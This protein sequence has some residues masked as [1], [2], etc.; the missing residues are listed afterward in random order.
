MRTKYLVSLM[1]LIML[2]ATSSAASMKIVLDTHQAE[3]VMQAFEAKFIEQNKLDGL[4]KSYAGKNLVSH[5]AVFDPRATRDQYRQSLTAAIVGSPLDDDPFRYNKTSDNLDSISKILG[6]I[7]GDPGQFQSAIEKIIN[8]YMPRGM[9]IEVRIYLV[10]GG[11]STGWTDANSEFFLD[12]N[13]IRGDMEGA[14]FMAAHEIFHVV[15]FE[16]APNPTYKEGTKNFNVEALLG[17]AV[18]EGTASFVSDF[19]KATGDGT[20]VAMNQRIGRKNQRRMTDNFRLLDAL[21]FQAANDPDFDIES[22]YRIAFSGLYDEGGYYVGHR[23]ASVIER[24]LGRDTLLGLQSRPPAEFFAAYMK[25][26]RKSGDTDAIPFG[27]LT[28]DIVK[29]L[30]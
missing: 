3:T 7:T 29:R 18:L 10:I 11:N 21:I 30:E 16:I 8:P 13:G 14:I 12:L 24:H 4:L 25:I 5:S 9:A 2:P 22:A 6:T 1:L 20:L 23:M 27:A 15:Q 17:N 28:E 26:S 19:E